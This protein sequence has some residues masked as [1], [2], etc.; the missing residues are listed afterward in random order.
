MDTTSNVREDS[1]SDGLSWEVGDRV[2]AK[3]G[4]R[5]MAVR[6]DMDGDVAIAGGGLIKARNIA[7]VEKP[8]YFAKDAIVVELTPKMLAALKR[9]AST[10]FCREFDSFASVCPDAM[11]CG[12]AGHDQTYHSLCDDHV[13][14]AWLASAAERRARGAA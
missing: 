11:C 12:E 6:N 13:V 4:K 3:S 2:T 9:V 8:F 14:L 5:G 7:K 10:K 1:Q